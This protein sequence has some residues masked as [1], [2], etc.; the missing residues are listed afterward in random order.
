MLVT[1]AKCSWCRDGDM[2]TATGWGRLACARQSQGFYQRYIAFLCESSGLGQGSR[3]DK[4]RV[5]RYNSTRHLN[6]SEKSERKAATK[7]LKFWSGR[8]DRHWLPATWRR[9]VLPN[10]VRQFQPIRMLHKVQ[11]VRSFIRKCQWKKDSAWY[12][13]WLTSTTV[14]C[15]DILYDARKNERHLCVKWNWHAKQ[16]INDQ[17]KHFQKNNNAQLQLVILI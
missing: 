8:E 12:C 14:G 2:R 13:R 15:F 9:S 6:I 10:H 5:D 3:C 17:Q 4:A 7:R 11:A 1:W 16:W